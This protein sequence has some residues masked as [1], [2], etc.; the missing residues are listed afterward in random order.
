MPQ[1]LTRIDSLYKKRVNKIKSLVAALNDF[2]ENPTFNY[3]TA[4]Y[5]IIKPL[6]PAML[7]AKLFAEDPSDDGKDPRGGCLAGMRENPDL[8]EQYLCPDCFKKNKKNVAMLLK[9]LEEII[10]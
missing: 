1:R 6:T 10:E 3:S 9:K 2:I 5:S 4:L 8:T 7:T